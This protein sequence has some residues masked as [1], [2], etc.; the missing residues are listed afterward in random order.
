MR[1]ATSGQ[2]APGSMNNYKVL[3]TPQIFRAGSSPSD[4]VQSHNQN[5]R[6]FLTDQ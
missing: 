2:N 1:G 6:L 5:T 4:A 3:H